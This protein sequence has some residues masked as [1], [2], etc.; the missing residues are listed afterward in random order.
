M[1]YQIG[2]DA[3]MRRYPRAGTCLRLTVGLATLT[4]AGIWPSPGFT[5]S[6]ADAYIAAATATAGDEQ[7]GILS[8]CDP[9]AEGPRPVARPNTAEPAKVFDNLYFLGIPSVSA[10]AL[11]T[12]AGIIVIDT[13]DNPQEAQ[14]YIEGGLR[15]LKLDPA[16]IK[17]V[18][19]T[20]AH[21]NHLGG[22]QYLA[23]KFHAT[24]VMSNLDWDVLGREAPGN[25]PARAPVPKR[26]KG[27]NDGEKL[28]LGDTTIGFTVTPP[29][30]PG[31]LSL[32]LPLKDGELSH[33]GALWGGTAFNFQP[34]VENFTTYIASAQKFSRIARD[35]G[36]DVPLSN[37][38]RYDD[39]FR[40]IAELKKRKPGDP[41][42][43]VLGP[44]SAETYLAVASECA[45]ASRARLRSTNP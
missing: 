9:R 4:V 6:T 7:R 25:N 26:G 38:A 23:D 15:K 24:L 30:T 40:K 43:F 29:H 12:S 22:A 42:P 32:I 28:T 13:L 39:A 18:I 19:V 27:V 31:T 20:H 34:T 16:Q 35:S 36:A 11:S 1:R 2:N 14:T 10:W 41:H 44:G 8:L 37:H 33:V 5:A 3:K 21:F 17:Y 45:M